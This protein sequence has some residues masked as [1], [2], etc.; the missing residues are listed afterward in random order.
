MMAKPLWEQI[1][2]GDDCKIT[3]GT[4]PGGGG[5]ELQDQPTNSVPQL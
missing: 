5:G 1:A 4:N 3:M 2:F